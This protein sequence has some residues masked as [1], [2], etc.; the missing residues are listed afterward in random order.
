MHHA[1]VLTDS[2]ASFAYSL[3]IKI[4]S[5]A[6]YSWYVNM[7]SFSYQHRK[8]G[9]GTNVQNRKLRTRQAKRQKII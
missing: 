5:I 7:T 4:H 6:F 8:A 9:L 2:Q 3:I 1:I